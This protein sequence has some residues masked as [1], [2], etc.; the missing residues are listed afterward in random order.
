MTL[1]SSEVPID[2]TQ[3]ELGPPAPS[4][5]G[6]ITPQLYNELWPRGVE[7][8]VKLSPSSRSIIRKGRC[9]IVEKLLSSYNLAAG[10][11]LLVS[12]S[13]QPYCTRNQ[14]W[15]LS[16]EGL[17]E[18]SPVSPAPSGLRHRLR[19]GHWLHRRPQSR[20][21]QQQLLKHPQRKPWTSHSSQTNLLVL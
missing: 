20:R 19:G 6:R 4:Y 21:Q 18:C 11:Y 15:R 3:S 14:Q 13:Q 12:L 5:S 1:P 16:F 7:H 10:S 17:P 2:K 8:R 9:T